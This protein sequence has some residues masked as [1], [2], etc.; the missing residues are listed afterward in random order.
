VIRLAAM[1]SVFPE[2]T[3]DQA[4]AGLKRHGYQGLEPRAEWGH[5]LGLELAMGP[6][7]RRQA[8]RRFADEGLRICCLA[9]GVRVAEPDGGR[10]A[11]HLKD[12]R[13]YLDL[14]AD[15]GC[16]LV[17]T[18]GGPRNREQE[19]QAVVEY[20]ADGY[21]QVLD[22]A[23]ERGVTVLLETHDDWCCAAPV[24]AVIER[25]GHSCLA[26]LWDLMHP[27]R[28]LEKAA[29]T[30]RAIG[31][32][33]RH[34]HVHDGHYQDGRMQL[35]ALG[36]GVI[37]HAEPVRLLGAAGYDGFYSVEMIH[38]AGSPHDADGVLRLYGEGLRRL[39]ASQ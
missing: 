30:F 22:Q 39:A 17:R 10:R 25:V 5:A 20:V 35:T 27:Q 1:S 33:T 18:F 38:Q 2:W 24:R 23:F 31:P 37:D 29:E 12:L 9:T 13:G 8:C 3:L 15:L 4:V 36:T 16:P 14:A 6:S 7:A 28:M 11:R 32:H 26:A 19:W 21:R 34:V